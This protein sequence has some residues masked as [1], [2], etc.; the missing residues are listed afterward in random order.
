MRWIKAIGSWLLALKLMWQQW[1]QHG[2]AEAILQLGRERDAY[3]DALESVIRQREIYKHALSR[4]VETLEANA[5]R[6]HARSHTIGQHLIDQA[7]R[8]R[9]EIAIDCND[10]YLLPCVASER[11]GCEEAIAAVRNICLLDGVDFPA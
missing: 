1:R 7:S 8:L 9:R 4:A 10:A 2:T 6:C 3:R 5:G 11:D